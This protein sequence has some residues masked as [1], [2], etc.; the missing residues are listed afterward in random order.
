MRLAYSLS[1]HGRFIHSEKGL[2]VAIVH[3]L[4][5]QRSVSAVHRLMEQRSE[6]VVRRLNS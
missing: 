6:L 2:A 4:M 5:E 3:R 1:V